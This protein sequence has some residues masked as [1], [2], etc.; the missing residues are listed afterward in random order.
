MASSAPQVSKCFIAVPESVVRNELPRAEPLLA[1]SS[2]PCVRPFF[3]AW[4]TSVPTSLGILL[5]DV[6]WIILVFV[7]IVAVNLISASP[8]TG[9][10]PSLFRTVVDYSAALDELLV[11]LYVLFFTSRSCVGY[12]I[13]ADP[14][15]HAFPIQCSG[16]RVASFCVR[17]TIRCMY[18][19]LC[20]RSYIVIAIH[21][22]A[23]H[24]QASMDT[25]CFGNS[26]RVRRISMTPFS[27]PWCQSTSASNTCGTKCFPCKDG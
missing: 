7:C 13:M 18:Y 24:C 5:S 4:S 15:P 26:T 3:F 12:R 6:V 20:I 2:P 1:G 14:L 19:V 9:H 17:R 16:R 21:G 25:P 8:G 23:H 10:R 22:V 11:G 27:L